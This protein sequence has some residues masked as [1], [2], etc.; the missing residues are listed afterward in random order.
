[1]FTPS[2]MPPPR[3][4]WKGQDTPPITRSW[5]VAKSLYVAVTREGDVAAG[6]KIVS[7]ERDPNSVPVSEV[8][9]LYVKKEYSNADADSV[10]RMLRIA[11]LPASRNDYF[12]EG[13]QRL[14]S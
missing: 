1:M 13:L 6:D 8:T 11:A 12:R 7:I 14:Q 9:R 10:R 3:S 5:S 4:S 2:K